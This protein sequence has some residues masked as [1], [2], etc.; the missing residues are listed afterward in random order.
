MVAGESAVVAPDPPGT[1]RFGVPADTRK[2]DG[3]STLSGW[4]SLVFQAEPLA[5]A[6]DQVHI[7]VQDAEHEQIAVFLS[8][9]EDVVVLASGGAVVVAV[10]E[11]CVL[12][13]TPLGEGLK[14]VIQGGQVADRL[15]GAPG[16]CRVA[17][18]F[19]EVLLGFLCEGVASHSDHCPKL[20]V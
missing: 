18:D 13:R 8:N 15:I 12:P 16:A 17:A 19:Q 4:G 2:Q 11:C 3:K 10:I 1:G 9:K 7:L 14:V 20:H 6:S 5:E